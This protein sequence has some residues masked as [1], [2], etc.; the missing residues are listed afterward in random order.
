LEEYGNIA[1]VV[2][3]FVSI[4]GFMFTL[5]QVWKTRKAAEKAQEIAREALNR[6]GHQLLAAQI[7]TALTIG[8]EIGNF[9]SSKQ[10][11]L[12]ID[13]CRQLQILLANQVED[14]R[15]RD[16]H[17]HI[18]AHIA[19]LSLIM[20]KL[21]EIERQE[22]M[23]ELPSREM[24]FLNKIVISLSRIDGRLRNKILEV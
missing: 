6:V 4:A 1:S 21:E 13:R 18:K 23:H 20:R 15:L 8:Q 11:N 7:N 24:E 3:L 5:Y 9:C 16:E 12:A 22:G 19:D 2:G 10:W 14:T 17:Q